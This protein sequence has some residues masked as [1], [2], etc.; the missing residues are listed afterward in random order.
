MFVTICLQFSVD[1]VVNQHIVPE[2]RKIFGKKLTLFAAVTIK[3]K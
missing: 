3:K 1:I 2:T